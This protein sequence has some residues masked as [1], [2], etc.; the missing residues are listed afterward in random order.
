MTDLMG[1]CDP[2]SLAPGDT[3]RVMV[4][5]LGADAFRCDIVRVLSAEAGPDHPPFREEVVANPVNRD[6][7]A[8]RQPIEIGSF[9][10]VP[11]SPEL[12]AC[13]SFT[14]SLYVY[15]TLPG[16]GRQGLAGTW[17]AASRSGFALV[18]NEAGAPEVLLGDGKGRI[19]R[20]STDIP[21]YARRWYFLAASFDAASGRLHLLQQPLADKS[22]HP[23][24]RVSAEAQT[25]VEHLV[26]PG[27]F[28]FAAWHVED[29]ARPTPGGGLRAGGFFN[30]KLDSPR[31]SRRALSEAEALALAG[32]APPSGLEAAMVAAWDFSADIA[33]E[34]IRDLS[35]NRL[36]G[37]TVNLPTRAVTGHNWRGHEMHW[38]KAPR[39][40]GA[41]HFHDDDLADACWLPDLEFPV[42][43]DLPSG[44][45]TVRL[46][47]GEAEF[48]VP[49]FV[50]P[51][52]GQSVAKLVYLASTATYTVYTNNLGRFTGTPELHHGRLT[53]LDATDE[54]LL[55]HPELGLSTYDR[56]RDGSGVCYSSRLR[57][58]TNVR[59][60]GRLWNYCADMFVVDWLSRSGEPFDVITDEDLHREGL[61]ILRPYR[62]LVTGSHPEYFSGAMLDALDAFTRGGGRLMYLGGNG[63][64]W[65]I[66]YHPQQP[67]IIEVRRAEDGTRAWIAE[68]G[69][70]YHSFDGEYGGLWRRQGR[71]PNLLAGVGFISQGF[72]ASTPYRRTPQSRDP[73]AA[74]VFD[75]IDGELL[76]D[77]GMLQGGAAGLE[78]D[79]YDAG[80]GS[81]PHALVLASSENHSNVYQL[82]AEEIAVAHGATDGV[83]NP[84]VRADLVFFETAGG[85]AVFSTGSIAYAGSLGSNNF[86]NNIARL[87]ANVLRRFLDPTPFRIPD[88]GR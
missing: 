46:R 2:Q 60:K 17:S 35:P 57:P 22:F 14:L 76:G 15:P 12:A 44:C 47:A 83:Q 75:G 85:G 3:L 73:R 34:R 5:C 71:P 51:S 66:A 31:L 55:K 8:R 23:A 43:Q 30:G 80:L 69:E 82:V 64:Y 29:V 56:H 39:E 7:P 41:I 77:F 1:Y 67:G 54:L 58:A 74:F 68:V 4:S 24:R 28:L 33:S 86:D 61:G 42:P 18:L 37:V 27:P 36:D 11:P 62:C 38:L 81:P 20:L 6:Y 72:D 53:V 87:T 21:L 50:R 49:F 70:Y 26:R 16:Q 84:R 48:H 19:G 63:F 32:D 59:P 65:R 45:Y 10:L 79:C 78:L 88:C 9:A 40:Y 25:D 13:E 52:R